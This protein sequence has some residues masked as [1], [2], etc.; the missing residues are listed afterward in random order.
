MLKRIGDELRHHIAFTAI[1]AVSGIV[2]MIALISL[3][4]PASI[5]NILFNTLH[6]LHVVLS[7]VTTT[8]M[9]RKYGG[10]K[11]WTVIL[12]GYVGSIGVATLSDVLIPYLGGT[13]MNIDIQLHIPFLETEKIPY[14]GVDTWIAVNSAAIFGIIIGYFWQSTKLPHAGHVFLS[15]WASLFYFTA[16]GVAQWIPLLPF[17]FLFLFL[18]VWLPCCI[19]D[20]IF[21]LLFVGDRLPP[22]H[23]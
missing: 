17:V 22:H 1:G 7:A 13:L 23:K 10:R 8:A 4:T 16:F 9:F 11:V 19:S 14:L 5:S 20:I 15:T 18:A 12:V 2:I 3:K 21:P 6:P